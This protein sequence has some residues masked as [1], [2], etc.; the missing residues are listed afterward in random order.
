MRHD[1]NMVRS[2]AVYYSGGI[3]GKQKYRKIYKDSS[4]KLNRNRNKNQH[5]AIDS[6]PLPRLVPYNRLMPHIK[7]LGTIFSV[8]DTLCDG[9]DECDRVSGCYRSLKE[10][11]IKLAEFFLSGCTDHP[12]TWFGEPYTF[13]VALGGDGA[14]FGKDDTACA[15]L[16]SLLNIGR[17]VLSSNENYLLFG[18]NCSENCIVVHRF[19]K[20]LLADVCDI[21]KSVMTCS[22]NGEQGNIKFIIGELPNDMK[23]LA[24]LS[25]ELSNSAKFYSSFANICTDNAQ[26][27]RG[28][29]GRSNKNTWTPWKYCDRLKVVKGV[30]QVK[31]KLSKQSLSDSTKRSKV[32]TFIAQKKSR[33][34]FEPL[35]R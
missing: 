3:T 30:E 7:S 34:E 6:C 11:L 10:L 18:A 12:I 32:T 15:W 16:V 22:H 5:L 28:T 13:F 4:Y 29:F 8:T 19:I 14:P 23:M 21:E 9:L 27:T 25:G 26:D 2:I 31:A 24:F 33:Q 20:M 1:E 17:G 35:L